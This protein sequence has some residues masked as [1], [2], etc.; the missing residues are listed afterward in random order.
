MKNLVGKK[1][2][3]YGM[4]LSGQAVCSLLHGQGACIS[5]YDD[6]NRFASYFN[7]D[8]E[9][10]KHNYDMLVV[11]PGVKVIGN[12]II[13]H[14]VIEKTPIYSELDIGYMFSRHKFIGIT[15][16]NGKTTV[17]SLVGKIFTEAG[18]ENIVCGNIGLPVTSAVK[19]DKKRGKN[20]VYITEVSNFQLELSSR[21]FA[22][23]ACI[24]NIAPD[25]LDRHGSMEEYVRVKKK[26][27][28]KKRQK[29]ILNFDDEY[30]KISKISKNNIYFSKKTLK[31]GVFVKNNAI[32]HNKTKIISLNDIPL[33]GEKNLENVL[34]SV[35]ISVA[36]KIKPKFI[37]SAISS[38]KPPAHRLQY[39][40]KVNGALVYDDS[41]AT[42]ISSVESA[43]SVFQN[44]NVVLL[45]GGKN[46]D[47][48]FD[49]F[50]KKGYK[51]FK[52]LCF[53]QAGKEI[54]ASANKFGYNAEYFPSMEEACERAKVCASENM[55]ILLSPACSSF[56]EFASFAVRGERFKEFM[57]EEKNT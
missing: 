39:L 3:V 16:T 35:A 47:F 50:F 40:G 4:G 37:R 33:L 44:I 36:E 9:P 8:K 15:G 12:S 11:S 30:S 23:T 55:V 6:E 5:V 52:L 13:S 48:D 32:Y 22:A 57:F 7:F 1:V 49:E 46:K 18:R 41:K 53:G 45:M 21:F 20:F 17:T 2:L 34:A 56:D 14:F 38:F 28:S 42:N 25:H 29:V 10:T 19:D 24:L 54:Q 27:L 51:I 31:Y 43:L 26:I